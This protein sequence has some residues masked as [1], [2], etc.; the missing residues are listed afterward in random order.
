MLYE[1]YIE[2]QKADLTEDIEIALSYTDIDTSKPEAQHGS[3][4]KSVDLPATEV[5]NNIFGQIYEL[6][7]AILDGGD[8]AI[9]AYFDPRKRTNYTLWYN[10]D[11]VEK[12][13]IKVDSIIKENG[14]LTYS[15]TLF[16]DLG[17]FFYNLMY[18]ESGNELTLADLKYHFVD[19]DDNEIDE[20][21][22]TLFYWDKDFIYDSWYN[23]GYEGDEEEGRYVT[24]FITAAPVYGGYSDDFDSNKVL[25]NYGSL[26]TGGTVS[27]LLDP[28]VTSNLWTRSGYTD[29]NGW[30]LGEAT[31]DLDEFEVRDLRS[32]NQR[33][34]IKMSLILDAIS[35]PEN[36]GGY[37]V[38]WDDEIKDS[39]YYKKTYLL[40]NRFDF[41][42][43]ENANSVNGLG[44][45]NI[46]S[47]TMNY[48]LM[49]T[50]LH[51]LDDN[52]K[53]VFDLTGLNSPHF[54]L[55]LSTS[56]DFSDVPADL[57]PKKGDYIQT[58]FGSMGTGALIYYNGKKILGHRWGG[59]G[60]RVSVMSGSTK[61]TETPTYF[62]S[63][64]TKNFGKGYTDWES[65]LK[66]NLGISD[67]DELV[68]KESK[69]IYDND[70]NRFKWAVPLSLDFNLP[71]AE[72]LSFKIEMSWACIHQNETLPWGIAKITYKE[73]FI[74]P[75]FYPQ[76]TSDS[77][78]TAGI[79]DGTI[80]PNVQKTNIT[81][82]I[83]FGDTESPYKYLI[84]FTRMFGAKYIYD[85]STKKIHIQTRQNYYLPEGY[86]ID[87][88]IDR[89]QT[90]EIQPTLSEYK[91][92]QYNLETPE[93]YAANLYKRKNKFDYGEVKVNSGYYFNNDSHKIFEDIPYTNGIPYLQKSLYYGVYQD[94]PSILVSPTLDV[95]TFKLS[96]DTINSETTKIKGYGS[97]YNTGVYKDSAGDKICAFDDSNDPVDDLKNCLLFYNGKKQTV[98]WYQIS[99][100]IPIMQDLNDENPCY[101]FVS[102]NTKVYPSV[103]VNQEKEYVCKW[104]KEIPVFSKYLTNAG[105]VYTDSLD[106]IKPAYTFI[107][108]DEN[109]QD[110]ITIYDRYWK[111]FIND[112]YDMDNKAVTLRMF[113]K[114]HPREAMR[115]FYYFDNT[116]WVISEIT[117]YSASSDAPTEVKFVKVY[118]TL[119]YTPLPVV[120][121][122]SIYK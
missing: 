25:I 82:K 96:G 94:V 103:D 56:L 66:A 75:T 19:D 28:I 100:N 109:Y 119:N 118:D 40:M 72:G 34:A 38:I 39:A 60:V 48:P 104:V 54:S 76:A 85:L 115:K 112:L 89:S 53:T 24:K 10:G 93:T 17:D 15:C 107:G 59:M 98:D 35:K 102:A 20:E 81:K 37:E 52:T 49:P 14:D 29:Y 55:E 110:N 108:N 18:D 117:D 32:V 2:G 120:W 88:W 50:T 22:G 90:I 97:F 57:R 30:I 26:P 106:F 27:D 122:N 74:L 111:E 13:Y 78:L 5:N 23:L 84:G 11:I 67:S 3:Y 69:L 46:V 73:G 116:V 12:G 79:Y 6:S 41:D 65:K 36:N 99:D 7:R 58:S 68:L 1:L 62:Y 91:W 87:R 45:L 64:L 51:D 77:E 43:D 4:S 8:S 114:E 63:T 47:S 92:Y 42:I 105:G 113:L 9:G 121:N 16:S 83:L 61:I 21:N 71:S 44:P 33:P 31:R 95:S 80:N 101:M 70:I 86:N